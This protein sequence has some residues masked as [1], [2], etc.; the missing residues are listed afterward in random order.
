LLPVMTEPPEVQ[1][2]KELQKESLTGLETI[3][4]VEDSDLTR[5]LTCENLQENGYEVLSARNAQEAGDI[6]RSHRGPIHLL[7]TDVV[8]PG[9]SG[10][11]LA[12]MLASR[13]PETK[14]LYMTGYVE[15]MSAPVSKKDSAQNILQK[16]FLAHELMGKVREILGDGGKDRT[17]FVH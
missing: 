9:M 13:R 4:V 3:L 15:A 11:R 2:P 17:R 10:E 14:V 6:A 16:P 12:R 5:K 7:L 1:S 8:M